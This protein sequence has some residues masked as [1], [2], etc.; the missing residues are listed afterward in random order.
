MGPSST[1]VRATEAASAL[2]R[3]ILTL[4]VAALMAVMVVVSAPPASAHS[5]AN[6]G[7][8]DTTPVSIY[9]GGQG[10]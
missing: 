4:T 10:S 6:G 2:R 1:T 8:G 7:C 5:M 9:R 3:K